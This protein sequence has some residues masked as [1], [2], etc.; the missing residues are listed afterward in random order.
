[1]SI[2]P[3][4]TIPVS[5]ERYLFTARRLC[6]L[7]DQSSINDIL[8]IAGGSKNQYYR[9][10]IYY[11]LMMYYKLLHEK[12]QNIPSVAKDCIMAEYNRQKGI[13]L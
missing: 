1:M 10:E 12:E 7:S 2:K 8:F 3:H 4:Q 13:E 5:A 9:S 6:N 11:S